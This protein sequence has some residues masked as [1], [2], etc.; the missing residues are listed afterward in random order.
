MKK[1]LL[2]KEFP[3]KSRGSST[4][5]KAAPFMPYLT[6]RW[7]EGCHSRLILFQ[8]IQD[9]GFRGSYSSLWRALN[10]F[11][12][13]RSPDRGSMSQSRFL[14]SPRQAAWLL[15]MRP[16][17]LKPDQKIAYPVFCQTS[18][19]AGKLSG[20]VRQFCEMVRNKTPENL[21]AWLSQAGH[22]AVPEFERF[23]TS[24]RSDYDVVKAALSKLE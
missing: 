19:T 2:L 14:L 6:K 3:T 23:A 10:Q 15:M 1:Y 24:L 13:Q 11:T 18:Q 9:Q 12:D 4:V 21:D 16:E 17:K 20:L 22:C 7:Q 5:S 8:E